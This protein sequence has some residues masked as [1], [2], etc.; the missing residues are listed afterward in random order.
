VGG[1]GGTIRVLLCDDVVEV[2]EI[3]RSV[4]EDDPM[5]EIVGDAGTGR[6]ATRMVAELRPDV[7]VLD[8]S[9][10]E[11]DG[12]EAIPLMTAAAPETRIVVLSGFASSRMAKA[13]S[14]LGAHRYIEK[15]SPLESIARAVREVGGDR[16]G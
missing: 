5:V 3:L 2:R 14:D 15:G 11:M 12:L 16:L 7:V 10:P 1:K 4:L 8:L 9:M 13:V 6:E